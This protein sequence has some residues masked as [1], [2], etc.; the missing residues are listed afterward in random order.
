MFYST[1]FGLTI[2]IHLLRSGISATDRHFSTNNLF[3]NFISSIFKT[4]I[5]YSIYFLL[6]FDTN[7]IFL[8]IFFVFH[9]VPPAGKQIPRGD[10]ADENRNTIDKISNSGK[11]KTVLSTENKVE[12]VQTIIDTDR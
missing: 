10:H 5:I 3:L 11:N 12:K 9:I 2:M 8:R 6:I 1:I 7:I 4:I